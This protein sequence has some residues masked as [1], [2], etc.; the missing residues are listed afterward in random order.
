MPRYLVKARLK[1]YWERAKEKVRN[2]PTL[3]KE[4]E[5]VRAMKAEL[6]VYPVR[7]ARRVVI[8]HDLK[9]KISDFEKNNGLRLRYASFTRLKTTRSAA[10]KI[11]RIKRQLREAIPRGTG[12]HADSYEVTFDPLV[13]ALIPKDE[14]GRV[15][16]DAFDLQQ[17]YAKG[18]FSSLLP[19]GIK[20][21]DVYRKVINALRQTTTRKPVCYI[22]AEQMERTVAEDRVF[23]EATGIRVVLKDVKFKD[24]KRIPPRVMVFER[25]SKAPAF[26]SEHG[27]AYERDQ[28]GNERLILSAE[29]LGSEQ[30][31]SST[32]NLL[33]KEGWHQDKASTKDTMI[34]RKKVTKIIPA[35]IGNSELDF[36]PVRGIKNIRGAY[37]QV[38]GRETYAVPFTD[39]ARRSLSKFE[40]QMRQEG[41]TR[42][43]GEE[44][45]IDT[46]YSF[47]NQ[48]VKKQSPQKFSD[49]I[50]TPKVYGFRGIHI[51]VKGDKGSYE[52][53]LR[54]P[55]IDE[56]VRGIDAA[57][58]YHK[59]IQKKYLAEH[60]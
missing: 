34:L 23:L 19:S 49:Y 29:S 31:A 4:R 8:E 21:G 39:S 14:T 37:S 41:W 27:T 53:Q 15:P 30:S 42:N 51:L 57:R 46:I 3:V 48:V 6:G 28:K 43:T 16:L 5:R 60:P 54:T 35:G 1:H 13:N 25:Q 17:M 24:R 50:R 20:K 58:G 40:K 55:R 22:N 32:L 26:L 7:S 2:I 9:R 11:D 10:E 52:L 47:V 33:E 59:W 18:L 36:F 12:E 38:L 45:L 44:D 56:E